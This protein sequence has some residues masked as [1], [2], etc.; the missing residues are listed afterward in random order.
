MLKIGITGGIGSG[1]TMVCRVFETLGIPVFYADSAAKYLM[2]NDALV[3]DSIKMLF[4]IDIYD[5]GVL[6]REKIAGIVFKQPN[7]LN[8]LNSIV[9]PA[10]IRYGK[11]WMESQT[12]PYVIK[13]AAIFFESGS[14]TDMDVMIGVYAPRK[15][16]ILRASQRD[17][18]AQ[19]KILQ[20]IAQQMDEDEKMRLCDHVITNDD[21]TPVIP[22]VLKLH[23][24]LLEKVKQ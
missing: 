4:G 3:I 20:R 7:I 9:H 8:E 13:E 6:N 10:T 16:R 22:Q 15:L 1:K 24:M 23:E 14:N 21:V 19:E 2:E 17:N 5:A 11:Q 12:S 18:A